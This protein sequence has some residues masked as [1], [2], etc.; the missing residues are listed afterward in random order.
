[1]NTK[2]TQAI[3]KYFLI[4]ISVGLIITGQ[5]LILGGNNFIWGLIFSGFAIILF[6]SAINSRYLQIQPAVNKIINIIASIIK[7]IIKIEGIPEREK[8]QQKQ[9]LKKQEIL[10]PVAEKTRIQPSVEEKQKQIP[11]EISIIIPKIL[12]FILALLLAAVSQVFLLMHSIKMLIFLLMMAVISF[13]I[14]FGIK[15]TKI[16]I[17]LTVKDILI[18]ALRLAG[19]ALITI[20]WIFLIKSSVVTQEWGVAFTVSGVLL[21]FILLPENTDKGNGKIDE[22]LFSA[23]D[24]SGKGLKHSLLD[25]PVFKTILLIAAFILFKAGSELI[26]GPKGFIGLGL[27]FL[28]LICVFFILPLFGFPG[29][30]FNNKYVNILK[31]ILVLTALFIAYKAQCLFVA[32]SPD[33]A[34]FWYFAAALIFIFAFPVHVFKDE[35]YS[36]EEKFPIKIEIIYLTV[37]ILLGIF[38]M[39]YELDLR[40][41][42]LENDETG[43]FI[44]HLLDKIHGR[45]SFNV[46]NYGILYNL[47]NLIVAIIGVSR[48]SMKLLGVILGII[49]I[50]AIYF[51]VRK[52][53]STRAAMFITAI[54]IF[55]RIILHYERSGHGTILATIAI[56]AAIYFMVK[57]IEK[58][59]KVSYFLAGLAISLGWH[60]LMTVFL[61]TVMPILYFAIKI[62]TVKGFLRKNYIGLIAFFLGFWIFA[63]MDMHNYFISNR[64]YFARINEVSVFSKDPN[65][66]KNPAQGIL[67]NTKSV[68]LMFNHMGDFRERNS[69]GRNYEPT[70]DFTSAMFFALGFIY[71]LYYSRYSL[72]FIVLLIFFSQAAGS[73]FSIEAPSAMRAFGTIIPVFFFI[74]IIFEKIRIAFKGVFGKKWEIVYLPIILILPLFFIVKANYYQ[75]F[76]RWIGGLDELATAG[77]MYSEK[78]G[79]SYR[80]FLH[81]SLYYPGHPPYRFYRWDYKVN[82]S[83]R[84]LDGLENLSIITDENYAVL[85]QPDTW[86]A[87][88]YWLKKFPA[89]KHEIITQSY[90]NKKLKG[91][92]GFGKFFDSILIS[93]KEIQSIK[94]LKGE[95]YYSDG[96][97]KIIN[98][99]IPEFTADDADKTPYRVVWSGELLV[100]YY[101]LIMFDNRGTAP[102]EI[103]VDNHKI[104]MGKNIKLAA[105]FHKFKIEARRRTR[106]DSIIL[107]PLISRVTG[108]KVG[109]GSFKMNKDSLY[110]FGIEGLHEYYYYKTGMWNKNNIADEEIT[111]YI[112][113]SNLS[114]DPYPAFKWQ[115]KIN[116]EKDGSYKIFTQSNGYVRI[117][118][119][120]KQ[121]WDTGVPGDYEAKINDFFKND[122]AMKVNKFNLSKGEHNIEIYSYTSGM[123]NLLWDEGNQSNSGV[124]LPPDILEPDYQITDYK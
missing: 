103:F 72:Y 120:K 47:T 75:Y 51:F 24:E 112:W 96:L 48:I 15:G 69:G 58:R 31:L 46:G 66:P 50:P 33:K 56:P 62:A 94:G 40:P 109:T 43:G 104:D 55:L 92:E 12:F 79:K 93:N 78:I 29:K 45:A 84:V 81:T 77:G 88:P 1:M 97:K 7:Q 86:D 22:F 36:E 14:F 85:L 107:N 18:F 101:S 5:I 13:F 60:S 121:Y 59:D 6:F 8:S 99:D 21:L 28:A 9:I 11:E 65:A 27:Y 83:N 44:G 35:N 122:K 115:G 123:I 68:L 30:Y 61:I 114:C 34:I 10:K 3:V 100:P 17:R 63:S 102:A 19:I 73:I 25:S 119:E 74:G 57:A 32:N 111:P 80:I 89:A 39:T 16:N 76:Q 37:A 71:C 38:L 87:L 82:S 118:I 52:V 116:I 23:Y 4:I 98:N 41:F 110:S 106:E 2:Y 90:F 20:G 42:G 70:I 64:I 105:G 117:E 54:F 26:A 91:N 67:N 124:F 95:Y 49:A 53:I 113:F 108:S